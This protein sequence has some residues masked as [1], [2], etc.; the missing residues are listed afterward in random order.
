MSDGRRQPRPGRA[1]PG[2]HLL[3][4]LLAGGPPDDHG[5]IRPADGPGGLPVRP[6]WKEPGPAGSLRRN[7]H[8]IQIPRQRPMLESVVQHHHP[9]PPAGRFLRPLQSAG[10][11]DHGDVGIPAQMEVDLVPAVSS[12]EDGGSSAHL[13]QAPRDPRR[14]GRLPRPTHREVPDGY[15]RNGTP[16][17]RQPASIVGPVAHGDDGAEEELRRDRGPRREAAKKAS[18]SLPPVPH[19]LVCAPP[20][21]LSSPSRPHHPRPPP[22]T[23]DRAPPPGPGPAPPDPPTR[24]PEGSRR[25]ARRRSGSWRRA[26]GS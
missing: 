24:R 15:H 10:G 4:L 12:N 22:A 1:E 19:P 2:L 8:D 17:D 7:E 20:H 21:G 6:T 11:H 23:G 14:D 9:G 18:L 16:P 13:H 3:R 5:Q 25:G 26:S